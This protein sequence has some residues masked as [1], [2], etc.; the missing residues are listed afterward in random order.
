MALPWYALRA[1]AVAV[2]AADVWHAAGS[3]R[4]AAFPSG[5][6]LLAIAGYGLTAAGLIGL[7]GRVRPGRTIQAVYEAGIFAMATAFVGWMVGFEAVARAG[8]IGYVA[9]AASLAFLVADVFVLVLAGRL[10]GMAEAGS[11]RF[12][13]LV[14]ALTAR[15][16]LDAGLA[17]TALGGGEAPAAAVTALALLGY[18]LWVRAVSSLPPGWLSR[19]GERRARPVSGLHLTVV[20]A[21]V[22]LG[23]AVLAFESAEVAAA[24]G[25]V[26]V[27]GSGLLS[28]LVVGYLAWLVH[29]REAVEHDDPT[30][31]PNRALFER[32]ARVAVVEAAV[33]GPAVI[34][35]DL[36]RLENV[37]DTLGRRAADRL[38]AAVGRRAIDVAGPAAIVARLGAAEIGV[39]LA[40]EP[41]QAEECAWRLLDSLRE[42]VMV[43]GG[44]FFV[45]PSIGVAVSSGDGAAGAADDLLIHAA[46]ATTRA[47]EDGGSTVRVYSPSMSEEAQQRLALE[48]SLHGA[49]ERDELRLHYQPL[50][51]LGTGRIVGAEALLRWDSPEL[52]SVPPDV[53]VPLAEQTGLI[54][55]LGEWVLETAC[56]QARD[57]QDTTGHRLTMAVNL[58]ARQFRQETLGPFVTGVLARSGL[59]PD[60]LEL[61]ITERQA[62]EDPEATAETLSALREAGVRCSLDD[63]GTGYCGLAYLTKF[64]AT[65]LKI[66]RSFV[67]GIGQDG[68]E[69]A[70]VRGVIGLAHSLGLTVIA[71]GIE[72]LDQLE[73]LRRHGCDQG[74]GYLFDRP[75]PAEEMEKLLL[76]EPTRLLPAEASE[77]CRVA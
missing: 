18:G 32:Q 33:T 28:L 56:A 8:H 41:N 30:G 21:C 62:F 40:G 22:L 76:G 59:D 47:R 14:L 53:F 71:E 72:S 17:A 52:G 73:F 11:P 77:V 66:D 54:V 55:A 10:A 57:W 24:S 65:T 15:L 19:T 49:L 4:A 16:A 67:Q 44:A 61:E 69:G 75:L 64:P 1:A 9:G 23:P 29:H 39:L 7:I 34:V 20:A 50:V 74:Q 63:F 46:T 42:P 38:L 58:S 13:Y 45:M 60:C 43:A 48:T 2:I 3:G 51:D 68:D 12:R 26:P 6:D 5:A 25:S 27:L 31:L 36:D 35:I 70:V 37:R